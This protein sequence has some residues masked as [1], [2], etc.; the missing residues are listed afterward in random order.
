MKNWRVINN[1]MIQTHQKYVWLWE[2]AEG[3]AVKV[4]V[5]KR[6]WKNINPDF[7]H[8]MKAEELEMEPFPEYPT[9]DG[10]KVG[11]IGGDADTH[12]RVSV[13]DSPFG[14]KDPYVTYTINTK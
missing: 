13:T 9:A 14:D 11:F 3:V 1:N 7:T 5:P 4:E 12:I 6:P 10:I 2:N 8:W